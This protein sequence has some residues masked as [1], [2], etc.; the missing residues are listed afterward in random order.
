MLNVDIKN[1]IGIQR[2]F[3]VY[4]KKRHGQVVEIM[5]AGDTRRHVCTCSL[6]E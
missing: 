2:A 6:S 3:A 5:F 1:V 4:E